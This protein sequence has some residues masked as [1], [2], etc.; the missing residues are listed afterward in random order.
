M[1]VPKPKPK[2]KPASAKTQSRVPLRVPG[3][4]A[5]RPYVLIESCKRK[6]DMTEDAIAAGNEEGEGAYMAG[7]LQALPALIAG[8]ESALAALKEEVC[9]INQHIRK[10]RRQF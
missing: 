7:R 4:S 10:K 1:P 2:P 6:R 9:Q 3:P 5:G 8:V